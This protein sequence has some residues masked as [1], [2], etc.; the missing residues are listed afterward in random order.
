MSLSKRVRFEV[1][2]RDLFTCQYCGRRPPDV[3]L[4][5]DH[6]VPRCKG[7]SDELDN[8]TTSCADCNRGK[9]GKGL[10]QVA[11]AVDEMARLEAIQ[12]MSER[13]AMLVREQR[14]RENEEH[15]V[16]GVIDEVYD[17]WT[18]VIGEAD[19]WVEIFQEQSIRMFLRRGLQ[20]T[21]IREAI[22]STDIKLNQK[23]WMKPVAAWRYFCGACWGMI[24]AKEGQE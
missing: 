14:A 9:A 24:R 6:I 1:F 19:A 17:Y 21:Q 23:R 15:A 5:A 16:L 18:R 13:A 22:D 2:K 7:G 3:V 4:E 20:V 11:P 10:D 12:E 8:L